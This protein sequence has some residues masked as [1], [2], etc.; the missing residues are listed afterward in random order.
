MTTVHRVLPGFRLTLGYTI[1]Y[2]SMVVLLPVSALLLKASEGGL[3]A[4]HRVLVDPRAIA[5]Y[6]MSFFGA[7]AAALLNVVFGS[8]VAW[9]LCRYRFPFKGFIDALVDLPFALPTAI[10]G[11]ALTVVYAE[12]GLLGGPL[13]RLGIKVAFAPLGVIVAMTFVGLPFVVRTV[14]PVLLDLPAEIEEVAATLGATRL[15]TL[16]RVVFPA[17]APSLLTGFALAF[18]RG[19]GEYGSVV[20]IS[21]NMP[22]RTEIAPLLIVTRIEQYD[23]EGATAIAVVMLSASLIIL[24]TVNLLQSFGGKRLGQ[25]LP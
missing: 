15:Q 24:F 17:L 10:A 14:Q 9:V 11:V 4:F 3:T 18:A 6:R 22:M 13:A 19:L 21:G 20:F 1:F 16:R 7:S 2:L 5:A 12:H 23:Y 25:R 8:F